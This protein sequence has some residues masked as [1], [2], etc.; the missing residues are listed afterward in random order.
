M[1]MQH[2]EAIGCRGNLDISLFGRRPL[3]RYIPESSVLQMNGEESNDLFNGWATCEVKWM[4]FAIECADDIIQVPG[5]YAS[6]I[7]QK[8][9]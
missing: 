2:P 6:I 3:L 4:Q 9:C 5:I 1:V 7:T 8:R